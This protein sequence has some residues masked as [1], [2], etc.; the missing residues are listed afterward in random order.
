[1]PQPQPQ[2]NQGS[3]FSNMVS[4]SKLFSNVTGTNEGQIKRSGGLEDGPSFE[5]YGRF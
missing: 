1:M 5:E 3:K 4:V 2:D